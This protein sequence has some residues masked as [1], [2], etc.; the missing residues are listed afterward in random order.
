MVS[1]HPSS[2]L[3]DICRSKLSYCSEVGLTI[4]SWKKRLNIQFADVKRTVSQPVSVIRTINQ[5]G[6]LK[7]EGS[8]SMTAFW[9]FGFVLFLTSFADSYFLVT[10]HKVIHPS[11]QSSF[12]LEDLLQST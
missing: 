1:P 5:C 11:S 7:E 12:T 2:I 8:F 3:S 6:L 10:L 9:W 4:T